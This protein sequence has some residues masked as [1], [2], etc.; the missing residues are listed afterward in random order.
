MYKYAKLIFIND[1]KSSIKEAFKYFE[2]SKNKGYEKSKQFL[3]IYKKMCSFKKFL[4]LPVE[5]Q[6]LLISKTMKATRISNN[7]KSK[8]VYTNVTIRPQKTE[9]LFFN[10]SLKSSVFYSCLMQFQN[11]YFE[12]DYPSEQFE[13]IHD[14]VSKLKKRKLKQL[15]VV[16]VVSSFSQLSTLCNSKNLK[17]C[18]ISSSIQYINY[19]A[20]GDCST[21]EEIIIPPSV[22]DIGS[23][24]FRGCSFGK[25]L[26][27]GCHSLL[28]VTIQ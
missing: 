12:L 26:L 1:S 4:E 10:N 13:I 7:P 15:E 5:K 19:R 6:Y 25:E 28:Q 21:L 27:K 18:R 17:F 2:L 16:I 24:S 14:F 23:Y 20:F 11:I 3:A 9:M 8:F 22:I